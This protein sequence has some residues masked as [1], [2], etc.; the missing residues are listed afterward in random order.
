MAASAAGSTPHRAPGTARGVYGIVR[1]RI[2]LDIDHDPP[3]RLLIY[4]P[5]TN[6]WDEVE[7]PEWADE[8]AN[9]LEDHGRHVGV[10]VFEQ[11]FIVI[12][13]LP[14]EEIPSWLMPYVTEW[15]D[16]LLPRPFM[17]NEGVELRK[18]RTRNGSIIIA[19]KLNESGVRL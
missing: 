13:A 16:E 1:T 18:Y 12:D 19:R 4:N 5:G 7:P 9:Y 6:K 15:V 14:R 8:V 2:L 17:V 10:G 3:A 11:G